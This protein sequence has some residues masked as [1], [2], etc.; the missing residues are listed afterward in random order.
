MNNR[1]YSLDALRGLAIILMVLSG[2]IV[3]GILPGWIYHGQTPPPSHVFNPEVAGITWVDLVFLFFLFALGAALPFAMKK[4]I[5]NG[6]SK[7]KLVYNAVLRGFQ[8]TFFAIFIQ[9]FYPWVLS[10][11]QDTRAWALSLLCFLLLFPMFMR[12]PLK[13]PA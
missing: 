12:I 1:S 13:M 8:L 10:N 7:L 6:E 5:D 4:R 3:F 9:H 11:P 2:S